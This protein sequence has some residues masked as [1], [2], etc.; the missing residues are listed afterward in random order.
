MTWSVTKLENGFIATN[1]AQIFIKTP[2]SNIK[3]AIKVNA[4]YNW[5]DLILF[6]GFNSGAPVYWVNLVRE[7]QTRTGIEIA[8]DY[9]NEDS[10]I[11][12][13]PETLDV[14][15]NMDEFIDNMDQP[16]LFDYIQQGLFGFIN[17]RGIDGVYDMLGY[18]DTIVVYGK[19]E[20]SVL[21]AF[22]SPV[23]GFSD[24]RLT[25]TVGVFNTG[26][27]DG[28]LDAHLFVGTD[29]QVWMY[30]EGK[31]NKL[32]YKEFLEPYDEFLVNYYEEDNQYFIGTAGGTLLVNP[33]QGA[34]W[35][36]DK[37]TGIVDYNG[38]VL[39]VHYK[40][41]GG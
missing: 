5:N 26:A 12:V 34:S 8:I 29:K 33:K 22:S 7:Y 40:P 31:L 38:Q 9:F 21:T 28:N 4:V 37:F 11:W 23:F 30:S 16:V 41:L 10:I 20:I 14:L 1:G 17:L 15:F 6:G 2:E 32:G 35:L 18:K 19:R 39:S 3:A 13:S 25:H 24:N 27:V 36:K